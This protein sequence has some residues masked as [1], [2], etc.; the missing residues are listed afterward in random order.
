MQQLL[1]VVATG[2]NA[3]DAGGYSTSHIRATL[4]GENSKTDVTYAGDDNL[5]TSTCLYSCIDSSL[6]SVITPKKIKYVTG[7][8]QSSYSLNDDI[9]DNIWLFSEREVY[10]NGS[11]SGYTTEGI[12]ISGDGY[13][14]FGNTD[15][16]YAMSYNDSNSTNRAVYDEFGTSTFW[17]FRSPDIGDAKSVR[18]V[19]GNG[20]I[21]YANAYNDFGLAFGFCID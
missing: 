9:A 3:R 6:R 18:C 14:K 19:I 10:G 7:T 2:S 1:T 20:Q 21:D 5:T 4:I 11:Y 15:S 13:S 12:G 8:S 16:K 17:W